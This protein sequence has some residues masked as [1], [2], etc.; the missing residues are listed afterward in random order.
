MG[1]NPSKRPLLPRLLQEQSQRAQR[2]AQDAQ[3]AELGP[4]QQRGGTGKGRGKETSSSS[5]P[6]WPLRAAALRGEQSPRRGGAG[7]G[8]RC[9]SWGLG[10]GRRTLGFGL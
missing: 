6:V 1:N 7:N 9:A 4:G 2:R 5:A 8:G 3:S 10:P